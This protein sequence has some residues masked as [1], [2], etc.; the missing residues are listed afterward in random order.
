[1]AG[2]GDKIDFGK[3]K[4]TRGWMTVNDGVMGGRSQGE[5]SFTEDAMIFQGNL[6]LE[7]NGGFSSIRTNWGNYDLSKY[8]KIIIRIKGDGRQYGFVL[9]NASRFYLPNHKFEFTGKKGEW[10]TVEM[11]LK[12]FHE[13]V[14]GKKTGNIIQ[15]ETLERIIRMGVILSDKIEGPFRLEIDY[16]EFRK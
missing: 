1:M 6:S 12:A 14:M 15:E 5:I 10:T 9:S 16:M 7:N 11:P 2:S 13:E 8:E 4:V 3:E